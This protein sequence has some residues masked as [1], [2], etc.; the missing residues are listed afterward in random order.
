MALAFYSL[1][2]FELSLVSSLSKWL[3]WY[4]VIF[5]ML[6][7]YIVQYVSVCGLALPRSHTETHYQQGYINIFGA[8]KK[9][10]KK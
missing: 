1:P 8:E 4:L 10:S 9:T 6:F 3:A 5:K 7:I 2:V